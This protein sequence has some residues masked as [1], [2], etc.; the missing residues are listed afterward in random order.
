MRTTD[1]IGVS[2]LTGKCVKN[3]SQTLALH[4]H[5]HFCKTFVC[6]EVFSILAKV[7]AISNILLLAPESFSLRLFVVFTSFP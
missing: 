7:H 6:P 5:M 4:D 3:N 2:A 1:Y